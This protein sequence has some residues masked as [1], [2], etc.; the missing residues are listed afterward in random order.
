M[1]GCTPGGPGFESRVGPSLVIESFCIASITARSWEVGG[2]SPPCLGEHVK[3]VAKEARQ[4]RLDPLGADR[5][6]AATHSL[7]AQLAECASAAP[8]APTLRNVIRQNFPEECSPGLSPP[9]LAPLLPARAPSRPAPAGPPLRQSTARPRAVTQP[10][11]TK[12]RHRQTFPISRLISST[13]VSK[14]QY[15]ALEKVLV[16]V[17]FRV[18]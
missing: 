7:K 2:V 13:K 1:Y 15:C 11:T 10:Y 9:S 17:K 6:Q 8:R 12:A 18:E 14:V 16:L 3:A 5:R 4:R